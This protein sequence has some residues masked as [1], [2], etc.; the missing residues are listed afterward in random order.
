MRNFSILI[1][2]GLLIATQSS[3]SCCDK[4]TLSIAGAATVEVDPDIAIFSVSASGKGKTSA[5]ALAQSNKLM[6]QATNI[7]K[8]YGLPSSNYSTTSLSLSPEYSY[9]DGT[10]YLVG[11][12]ATQSLQ[13][14]IGQLIKNKDVLAKIIV[15][16]ASFEALSI[17][18][19]SF[20]NYDPS[21][22]YR[23]ARKAAVADA[24][25]KALQY[26][27]LSGLCLGK[28]R[29]IV[30]NNYERYV[31]YLMETDYY[32][33]QAKTLQIPFGKV[34]VQASVQI[35]WKLLWWWLIHIFNIPN[36]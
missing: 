1:F 8:N 28:V 5:D 14:T 23:L 26:S 22:A 29:K 13:V 31:P 6:K 12:T 18:G 36:Y 11:Q 4:N 7:L 16:L 33:F 32:A 21:N 25:S 30:D 3:L 20:S 15:A 24:S 9:V 19:F 27:S 34:Q 10:S 35:D 2:C 17:S